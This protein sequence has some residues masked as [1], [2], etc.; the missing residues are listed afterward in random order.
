MI[1]VKNLHDLYEKWLIEEKFPRPAPVVTI[2]AD[3]NIEQMV[4]EYIKQE[5]TIFGGNE[6]NRKDEAVVETDEDLPTNIDWEKP[7]YKSLSVTYYENISVVIYV[8]IKIDEKLQ[9]V[10]KKL[11]LKSES[12][13]PCKLLS[14]EC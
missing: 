4:E 12:I 10:S 8:L 14:A 7:N 2:N 9:G 11:V 6:K 5:P 3:K 1:Q 13:K